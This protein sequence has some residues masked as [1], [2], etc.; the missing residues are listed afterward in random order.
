VCVGLFSA[1]AQ[2][3]P[4]AAPRAQGAP[5]E[6]IGILRSKVTL[7]TVEVQVTDK[8]GN[9]VRGLKEKDFTVREDGQRQRIAFFDAGAA[10]VTVAVLVDSSVSVSQDSKVGSAEQV[11]AEFTRIAQP[12]DE[13]YAMDFT[14]Q[15]G[16]FQHLTAEQLRNPGPLRVVSAGGS[17]SAVYDAIATA[18][19]HLRNSKNPRQAIVVITDGEDEHS[20]LT[21]NQLIDAVRS[22]RAQLFLIR[23]QSNRNFRFANHVD[24]TVTLQTGRDIDNPDDV[25]YRLAKEDGATA[26]TLK[27]ESSLQKALKAVSDMLNAEYTLAYYPPSTR[28]KVRKVQVRVDRHGVRVL[29]SRTIVSNQLAEEMVDYQPGTCVVSSKAY[30]YPYELHISG[31]PDQQIYRDDFSSSHSGWPIHPDSR[32][33]AGGYELFTLQQASEQNLQTDQAF[34]G[35][36]GL[37]EGDILR[38]TE[39]HNPL[40][41]QNVIAAYGPAWADF[42]VSATV[43]LFEPS[44]SPGTAESTFSLPARSAAGLVF[45]ISWRGY[46]GFLISWSLGRNPRLAFELVARKFQ[47]DSYVESVIIPWTTIV[48][49]SPLEARLT[50]QDIGD[51]IMLFVDGRQVGTARDESFDEGNAGLIVD[52][53]A[54]AIFSNLLLEQK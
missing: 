23:L 27:S 20:R 39:T 43:R 34:R 48:R 44:R 37:I 18:I 1:P 38:A 53:P 25:F 36:Q 28:R 19:C 21:L 31:K 16:P 32:Y 22:Q 46:Y 11:A 45:R 6:P 9:R 17:G 12:G 35:G 26:F 51:Q 3:V 5:R 33:V 15:T 50:V 30:P 54:H 29:T 49:E 10:P 42:R 7:Q 47:G 13:T 40:Y 8:H 41:R 4:E 52:A 14:D 2:C 24:P